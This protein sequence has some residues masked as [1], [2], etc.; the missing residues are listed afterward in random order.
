MRTRWKAVGLITGIGVSIFVV[1]HSRVSRGDTA[2]TST[3]TA[4]ATGTGVP[5]T[6]EPTTDTPEAPA[7]GW[8]TTPKDPFAAYDI[9]AAGSWSYTDLVASERARIDKGRDVTGWDNINGAFA[10]ASAGLA[11]QAATSAATTR[12]GITDPLATIGVVP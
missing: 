9:G 4:A 8:A 11:R 2:T 7:P 1:G 3:S 12:L 10:T 6:P 5:A